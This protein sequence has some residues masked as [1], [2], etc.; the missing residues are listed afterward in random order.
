M[1][2]NLLQFSLNISKKRFKEISSNINLNNIGK[3]YLYD[4]AF[5]LFN[6]KS[7]YEKIS[8]GFGDFPKKI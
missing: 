4:R 1:I 5:L 7:D 2:L 8:K 6:K 3:P